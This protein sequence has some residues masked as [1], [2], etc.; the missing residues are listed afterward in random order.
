MLCMDPQAA[1]GIWD[2]AVTG[3]FHHGKGTRSRRSVHPQGESVVSLELKKKWV[4][5]SGNVVV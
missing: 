1:E 3:T 5:P 4:G 2:D